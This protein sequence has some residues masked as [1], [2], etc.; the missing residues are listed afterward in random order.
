M[1]SFVKK[2][3]VKT[4]TVK[5]DPPKKCTYY[6]GNSEGKWKEKCEKS[7]SNQ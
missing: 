2:E 6:G 7:E 3:Y 1:I 5:K 4:L